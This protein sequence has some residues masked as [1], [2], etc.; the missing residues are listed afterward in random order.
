ME[1]WQNFYIQKSGAG[2]VAIESVDTWG[3]FCKNI[4]F[5]LYGDVKEPAKVEYYDEHGDDEY[6]GSEGL[7]LKSYSIEVEFGCKKMD[8]TTF[9][10]VDDVRECVAEF[11]EFLRSAG[12]FKL[13]S[14]Y[15]RIGRQNVRL[16]SIS[17]NAKWI[18]NGEWRVVNNE[19]KYVITEEILV[20]KVK[21]KVNDPKTNVNY[22][23][24]YLVSE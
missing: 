7:Y 3:V 5:V 8:S 9:G 10:T 6:I 22:V 12:L 11:L 13:Y 21:F 2:E 18:S 1:R 24:G 15:T 14:S 20:F 16:E 19:R 4:P 17:D 23:D